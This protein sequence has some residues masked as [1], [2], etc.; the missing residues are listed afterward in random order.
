[1]YVHI[2]V[3]VISLMVRHGD[4]DHSEHIYVHT[5]IYAYTELLV[6]TLTLEIYI[7]REYI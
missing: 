5:W 4:F 1:M 7:Y 6:F 2:Y 3:H